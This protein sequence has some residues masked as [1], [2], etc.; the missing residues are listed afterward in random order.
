MR[1]ECANPLTGTIYTSFRELYMRIL[2]KDAFSR[3]EAFVH[4]QEKSDPPFSVVVRKRPGSAGASTSAPKTPK[5]V[6]SSTPSTSSRG[7]RFDT[8]AGPPTEKHKWCAHDNH[9]WN[10]THSTAGCF[11]LG[12]TKPPTDYSKTPSRKPTR[13]SQA[14]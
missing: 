4:T 10:T 2:T 8:A 12:N 14:R 6:P 9:G 3:S 1:H 13:P 7:R 11:A 5:K